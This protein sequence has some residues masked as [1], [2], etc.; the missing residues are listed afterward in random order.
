MARAAG[1]EIKALIP[2]DGVTILGR[3]IS[4]L[5]DTGVVGKIAVIGGEE[6]RTSDSAQG[7]DLLIPEG[8]SGPDNIQRGLEALTEGGK[9][10]R[11]LVVTTDLPLITPEIISRFISACPP[12]KDICVPLVAKRDYDGA[13]PGSTATF[14][15]LRDGTWTTGCAYVMSVAALERSRPYIERV[16]ENRKSKLGMAKLLGPAFLLKFLTKTLTIPDVERK[17]ESLL[18]CSGAAVPNSPPELAYD[19][20]FV[21]DYE[22]AIEHLTPK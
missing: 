16:F 20:D 5:R 1:T 3:T 19:I 18:K 22:Y 12:D 11:V 6:L 4:A 15:T 14:V 17:I 9:P 13:F 7:A 21:D 2:F 8:S 10:E